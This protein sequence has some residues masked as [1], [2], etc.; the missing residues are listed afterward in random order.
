M[1][2]NMSVLQK[3]RRRSLL[4][5]NDGNTLVILIA[6]NLIMFVMINFIKISY[7]LSG[8]PIENYYRDIVGWIMV[9]G[10]A[11]KLAARPW[12]VLTHMFSHDGVWSLIGTLLWLWGFGFIL[13]SLT[14]NRHLAPLYIYGGMAGV[15]A[16][17]LSINLI[18]V[19]EKTA[20]L[21]LLEGGKASVMAIAVATTALAPNYRIFPMLNGGIPLWVI[22]M[23]FV[24]IDYALIASSG[25]GI[26][27]A[28]LAGAGI[29]L[30]YMARLKAGSDW[31]EWMHR[32]YNWFFSLF[33]PAPEK[34][35]TEAMRREIFYK[36]D[37]QPPFERKANVTQQRVD[38]LLDKIN[39]KGIQTL[40]DEEREYLKKASKEG[41]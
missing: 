1:A 2:D 26:G 9:P 30:L 28:H 29:G 23:I 12:T 4:L 14:G 34:Q 8:A 39:Q 11:I 10:E 20:G 17:S 33:E 3:N 5:G 36:S 22:T 21:M 31:G 37:K 6:V 35:A 27:L 32:G 25:A 7:F 19:L 18:P 24:I 16:F 38:E 41:L 15:L 40:T 13:Q